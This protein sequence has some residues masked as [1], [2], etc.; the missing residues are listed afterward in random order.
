MRHLPSQFSQWPGSGSGLAGLLTGGGAIFHSLGDALE[1]GGHAKQV[2]GHVEFPERRCRARPLRQTA[3]L[4]EHVLL[5]GQAIPTALV[6]TLRAAGV[7]PVLSYGMTETCGGCVYNG[8]TLDG[9][10]ITIDSGRVRVTGPVVML[11][12]RG[13]EPANGSFLTSDLGSVDA[14]GIITIDGRV[15]DIETINGVN[16]SMTAVEGLLRDLGIN[17]VACAGSS[18]VLVVAATSVGPDEQSV[19]TQRAREQ[20]AVRLDFR[21]T[22][23]VPTTTAGKVDRRQLA[24]DL[25]S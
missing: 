12:Y 6:E 23:D 10:D 3:I 22:R 15:D 2:V 9:V 14:G 19:A 16:V 13:S 1:D 11:G 25:E 24:R 7:N 5:G 17:A 8:V 4:V 21:V 18:A 20:F